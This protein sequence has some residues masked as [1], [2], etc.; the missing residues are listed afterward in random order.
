MKKSTRAYIYTNKKHSAKGIFA[1]SLGV[2]VMIT[3]IVMV[4]ISYKS[5]GNPPVNFGAT[6]L[7]CTLFSI[8][9]LVVGIAGRYDTERFMLFPVLAICLNSA[10]IL[11]ISTILYAGAMWA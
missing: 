6:A 11:F 4:V 1:T 5:G 10:D 9:G 2:I 3:L 8:V 7:L